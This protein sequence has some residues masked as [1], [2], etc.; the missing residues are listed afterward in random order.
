MLPGHG[1]IPEKTPASPASTLFKEGVG[2]SSRGL[3]CG[4]LYPMFEHNCANYIVVKR[5]VETTETNG[6]GVTLFELGE[7]HMN[8]IKGEQICAKALAGDIM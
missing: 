5:T 8:T 1:N 6:L 2:G 7:S 3:S 4:V